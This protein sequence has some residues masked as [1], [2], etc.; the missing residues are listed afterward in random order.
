MNWNEV[1]ELMLVKAKDKN[2]AD[3]VGYLTKPL[4]TLQDINGVTREV[5]IATI[6]RYTG[7]KDIKG[8]LIFDGDT[9]IE[10]TSGEHCIGTVRWSKLFCGWMV[11]DKAMYNGLSCTTYE[12]VI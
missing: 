1:N 3:R 7:C 9:V 10:H 5:D 4:G 12:R 11:G 8:R 6:R 2:G